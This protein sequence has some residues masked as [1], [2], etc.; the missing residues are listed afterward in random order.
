MLELLLTILRQEGEAELL[1]NAPDEDGLTPLHVACANI[2]SPGHAEAIRMLL[3]FGADASA[4]VEGRGA[5]DF[6][7]HFAGYG[8]EDIVSRL[9]SEHRSAHVDTAMRQTASESLAEASTEGLAAAPGSSVEGASSPAVPPATTG[10]A[11]LGDAD[12]GDADQDL[13]GLD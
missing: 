13:E 8:A 5:V 1:V 3:A 4:T 11:D 6:A 9:L 2:E 7:E 10:S 12:L